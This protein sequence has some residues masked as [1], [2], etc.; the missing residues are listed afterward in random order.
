MVGVW[1]KRPEEGTVHCVCHN[2]G[3]F[4]VLELNERKALGLDRKKIGL[5]TKREMRPPP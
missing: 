4:L 2:V 3:H 1:G 5:R